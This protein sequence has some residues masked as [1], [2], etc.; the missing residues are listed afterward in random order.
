MKRNKTILRLPFK[1]SWFVFWGGDTKKINHH[2]N[3]PNQ[4]YAFDFAIVDNKKRSHRGKGV[5]NK[6]YYAFGEKILSP[7]SGI[8]IEAIEGIRDNKPGLMNDYLALGNAVIIKHSKN[9]VSVLSHLMQGS[10]RVRTGDKVKAGQIVGLCGN[11]GNSSEPHL[12]YHLQDNEIIQDG[13]GIRCYFKNVK[14]KNM[15]KEEYTPIKKDI[16]EGSMVNSKS[17]VYLNKNY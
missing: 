7:A 1:G 15:V 5:T 10:L 11:S 2:H 3:V 13:K 4:K 16:I 17:V 9:E 6:E 12:H 14:I 8:V